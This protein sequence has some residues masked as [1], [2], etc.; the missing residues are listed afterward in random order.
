MRSITLLILALL[1]VACKQNKMVDKSTVENTQQETAKKPQ[2]SPLVKELATFAKMQISETTDYEQLFEVK[3]IDAQGNSAPL[4]LK[5]GISLY[6]QI[7]SGQPEEIPLFEISNTEDVVLFAS[8]KGYM[9]PIWAKILVNKTS[10]EIKK[11]AF[12]HKGESEGYGDAITYASFENKF[13]GANISFTSNTF[14]LKQD[15][16]KIIKGNHEVDGISGATITSDAVVKMMNDG[17]KKYQNY[18]QTSN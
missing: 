16:R 17:L 10:L 8:G 3:K 5:T 7:L 1:I 18:L 11:V 2:V 6:K 4:D 14:G 15:D 9:G 12:D 13:T